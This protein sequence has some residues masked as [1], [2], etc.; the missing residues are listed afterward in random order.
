MNG[1]LVLVLLAMT[2]AIAYAL[3]LRNGS[4]S[5]PP[6]PSS[7]ASVGP[8]PAAGPDAYRAGYLAGHVAG[9][10]DAEARRNPAAEANKQVPD[11][12][13]GA[14]FPR[15]NPAPTMPL[16]PQTSVTGP[17][18][19]VPPTPRQQAP[20]QPAPRQA[21]PHPPAPRQPMVA[22]VQQPPVP[23][24]T[25]EAA[26][27]RKEK[28]DQQNINITLYVASLLLVAAGALFVGTSLPGVFRFMGIWFITALFYIAGL[29]IHAK[30]P[31]LRPAAV[32]F[33]GTGLALIPVTGLAMYNFAL[34][35]GPAAWL[36]T[37]LLGMAIYSY[38]AVRLDNKVLAFLSLSFVVST[39]WSGVSVLGGALVWYFIAMIGVA[40]LLT[41]GALLRPRWIPP[42]YIR[43]LM[44]L[45]PFV[46]PAVAVAVTVTPA[47]LSRGEYALVMAVCGTY[48][49]VMAFV[50]GGLFRLQNAYAARLAFTLALLGVVWDLSEDVSL[51]MF[52][53]VVCLGVQSLGIAFAGERLAPRFWWN[54]AVSCLGL[55]LV[56]AA[57]L[58]M[59]LGIGE[60]DLVPYLPLFAAMLTAMVVGWKAGGR[61]EFA[62]GVVVAVAL[63]FMGVLGSWA[64]SGLLISAGLYWFLR[65]AIQPRAF[66]EHLVLAGRI[67]LTLGAPAVAAGIFEESD[68]RVA[69]SVLAFVGAAVLQQ[70]ANALLMGGGV[71]LLAPWAST[72]AFGGSGM[73]GLLI[74]PVVDHVAGR[75]A[76][77]TA[78]Y[79]VLLA[80]V[81]SG[82]LLF[83]RNAEG[84]GSW[85]P[86]LWE[87]LAPG[88]VLVA[89]LVG[90]VSV[91][92]ALGNVVLLVGIGYFCLT[93][94]RLAPSLH[95]QCYWWLAR[96]SATLLAASATYD[97]TRDKGGLRIAG[98]MP[99]VAVVVVAMC[100]LQLAL[101]LL[102]GMRRRY[103]QASMADA[104]VVLTVMAAATSILTIAGSV[105]LLP[106]HGWQPG[107]T[108]TATA[109]AAVAC[110][111]V[112]RRN[113]AAWIFA[114]VSLALLLALRMANIRDVEI[115][116]GIFAAYCGYMV[117]VVR[118]RRARGGYLLGIRVLATAFAGVVAADVSDS[119]TTVS[120]V[121]ASTL[122]LQHVAGLTVRSRGID[123]AFQ[124]GTVW[125]TLGVQL[126]LPVGYLLVRNFDGGGRWVVLV[127]LA[128]VWA[129]AE[130]ARRYLKVPGSEYFVIAAA[131]LGVV[132]AGPAARFPTATW[133]HQPLL[134]K[135]QVPMV[136]LAL[137]TLST[138]VR[139]IFV[140]R[141]S[142]A[143]ASEQGRG[144]WFWLS[145][146]LGFVVAGG[147]FSIGV[148]LSLT[149]LS[150]LVLALALFAASHIERVPALY[151]A[152]AP[153]VL[154]GSIV[155]VD[156]L[157]DGLPVGVWAAFMPWLLGGVGSSVL[158]YSAKLF[159]G[160]EIA[161]VLWR[162][163]ALTGTAVVG[164]VSAAAVGL[165]R[166]GTALAGAALVIAAG[167]LVVVEIPYNKWLAA[168]VAGVL[169]VAAFQRALLF[170]DNSR[171]DWFWAIQWY[172]IALAVLAG[173][174][175]FK[176]QR[177]DGL[178][179]L[180]VAAGV[181]SL[182][183]L[184]T[185]FGGTPAQQLYVLVAHVVLLAVGLLL[186]ERVI[187][188]WGAAGV[189]LSIMW[190]LRSYA[191]AMLAL[192]ALGLIVLAVWRLNKRPQAG[193]ADKGSNNNPDDVP[194]QA[195]D[196][197]R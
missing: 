155:T 113:S 21:A 168:E 187:V 172:A 44:M 98:E 7:N 170:V 39:A 37:S 115:L 189:A 20:Y 147:L 80:G 23:R 11:P 158:L 6:Y 133:L 139:C 182:T 51:V 104:G 61:V 140:A 174:R 169:S 34:H 167:V 70:V 3:G 27:A 126:A 33:V 136:L 36:V 18:S 122:V 121:I 134:D 77:V 99:S 4:K 60:F 123:V 62:P 132:L 50:P 93:A 185:I 35:D 101:P 68:N 66:R 166:D 183:S 64:L 78:V 9:W 180:C 16:P 184:G 159:G 105:G 42:L 72:A 161:G 127:E 100:A 106:K 143:P 148:S 156:G 149:G 10:R 154:V 177:S 128:L 30:V 2:G 79:L 28:R 142:G 164:L 195:K 46:V 69:A 43:P 73:A 119:A 137:S 65:G 176:G 190:A 135:Y 71:R 181:L 19:V 49:T 41:L 173:L 103:P 25:P 157:L 178:L 31:R 67:A 152:A 163:N 129:C 144:R 47:L 131:G 29:I 114:P 192:V 94:L 53:A 56:T 59:V 125:V 26:A 38:T 191:F 165:L 58:T 55:Q 162:R 145:A 92:L 63:P 74:L 146:A 24:E 88:A 160:R 76:L 1:L 91:S 12:H 87:F 138:V 22:S 108:A 5:R 141:G 130:I 193:V 109:L 57:A 85:R 151:V 150:M 8:D 118:E 110:G 107:F 32:A 117:S 188:W 175:Y 45:H 194:S 112:L 13:I 89:G 90:A 86:A 196:G 116:L 48:F 197:I 97:A 120:L 171:P 54:D 83:R 153:A 186:A 75:P 81:A 102:P 40:V 14:P 111:M 95:R 15:V 17:Y 52:A 84:D 124:Q 82:F 96:A 179:R